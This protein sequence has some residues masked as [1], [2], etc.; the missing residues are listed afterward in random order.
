MYVNA[1]KELIDEF[2]FDISGQCSVNICCRN[3]YTER[4]NRN[5]IVLE[6]QIE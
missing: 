5:H 2:L 4:S 6:I 3:M 1:L